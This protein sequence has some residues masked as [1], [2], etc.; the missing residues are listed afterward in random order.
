MSSKM[1]PLH[2]SLAS[3][4]DTAI[5]DALRDS[6]RLPLIIDQYSANAGKVL[7]HV[8][9]YESTPGPA[10]RVK[11]SRSQQLLVAHCARSQDGTSKITLSSAFALNVQGEAE[12]VVLTCA[13]TLDE[14]WTQSLCSLSHVALE[15]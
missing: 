1:L 4:L 11:G 8:L 6:A 9:P 14:V 2:R 7:K 15:E 12:D 3:V 5:L 13:H 10:R